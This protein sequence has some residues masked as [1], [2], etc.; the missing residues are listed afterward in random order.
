MQ[1]VIE[2]AA[3]QRGASANSIIYEV[4]PVSPMGPGEYALI[5]STGQQTGAYGG[6]PGPFYDFG[7][8]G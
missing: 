3:S 6:M 8:D 7:V 4:R 1:V 2:Q 5:V